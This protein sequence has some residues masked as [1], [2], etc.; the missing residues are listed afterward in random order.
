[1]S[2][3]VPSGR[4]TEADAVLAEFGENE[5]GATMRLVFLVVAGGLAFR[6]GHAG[7]TKQ[8]LEELRPLALAS[9]EP[10]RI[11]PMAGVILPWLVLTNSLE[12]LRSLTNEMLAVVDRQWPVVLDVVPVVRALASAGE[13][14][15]LERTTESMRETPN[16][17]VKLQTAL[18]VG[19]GLLALARGRA[20]EA[21][22]QLE[23]AI[24]REREIGR[25]YDAAC[26]EL[27]LARALEAAGDAAGAEKAR[28]RAASV[29]EPLG[30]VNA[31]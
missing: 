20:S 12:E 18:I 4:W 3:L 16:V 21:V 14:Q 25:T 29:L 6:R 19:E 10:Q 5:Q 11:I 31:F 23:T 1:M 2:L 17:S 26:L 22:E 13:T 30:C 8:L 7:A 15:L 28:A 9:G 27:D 24:E